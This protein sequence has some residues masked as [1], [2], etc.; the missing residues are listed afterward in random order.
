[1][2]LLLMIK[3]DIAALSNFQIAD[4]FDYIGLSL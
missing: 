1:M 4:L 2:S 3:L